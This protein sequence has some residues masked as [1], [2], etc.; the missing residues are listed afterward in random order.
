MP[1]WRGARSAGVGAHE[2]RCRVNVD[3]LMILV[4]AALIAGTAAY[5][6]ALTKI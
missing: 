2:G 5:L 4:L 6:A 3:L 1:A